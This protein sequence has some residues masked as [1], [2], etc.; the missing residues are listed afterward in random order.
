MLLVLVSRKV[1]GTPVGVEP[2]FS[3]F[4]ADAGIAAV[5]TTAANAA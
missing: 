3:T 4:C 5:R 2:T 1:K